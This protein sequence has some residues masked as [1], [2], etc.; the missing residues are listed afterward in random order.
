MSLGQSVKSVF[1]DP[2]LRRR[3]LGWPPLF[4]L[5]SEDRL[6]WPPP[7]Q[8]TKSSSITRDHTP[9]STLRADRTKWSGRRSP[10]LFGGRYEG[11]SIVRLDHV[12]PGGLP[13]YGPVC[14][15]G[16]P[17]PPHFHLRSVSQLFYDS[18]ALSAWKK[19]GDVSWSLRVNSASGNLHPT[20][21]I[22][23]PISSMSR[24]LTMESK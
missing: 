11:D 3:F 12:P 19:D 13:L 10:I 15:E 14:V 5:D 23:L 2:S 9:L 17:P 1:G 20:E 16:F 6:R 21:L 4:H 18:V 8:S 24:S 22:R 7:N